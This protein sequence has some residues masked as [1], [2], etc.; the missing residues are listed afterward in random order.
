MKSLQ[1]TLSGMENKGGVG[2][3][4]RKHLTAV[5]IND[6]NDLTRA[7]LYA[8]KDHLAEA[9]S[10]NSAKTITANLKAL[11]NRYE[12][13]LDLPKAWGKILSV[14]GA[15]PVRTFFTPEELMRFEAVQTYNKK[16]TIVKIESLVEAYT[17]A[18]ISDVMAFTEENIKDGVL[19]YVSQ[20]TNVR[21]S[22]PVS[23]KVVGWIKYAQEHRDNEPTLAGRN[24]I[25]RRLAQRAGIDETVT[26]F[27]AGKTVQ[28]PKWEQASSHIFRIS[29]VTNLQ[30]AGLDLLTISRLAGHTQTTMTE[31]YCAPSAPVINERG[32]RYL[33]MR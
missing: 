10:Q 19:T 9:V 5:G 31:R 20:K 11:L 27:R 13:E 1:E 23:E 26:V 29:F 15:K 12:E 4:L 25:I 16:E 6:W 3:T 17:G 33:L 24:N 8:L 28:S 2:Q 14:R 7:N 30:K 22:V 21:S 18:R 32:M